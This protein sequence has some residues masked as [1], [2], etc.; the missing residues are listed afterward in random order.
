MLT[1][2]DRIFCWW[3]VADEKLRM[4]VQM[5]AGTHIAEEVDLNKGLCVLFFPHES[6]FIELGDGKHSIKINT[7]ELEVLEEVN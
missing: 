7:M 3:F 1:L 4:C 6:L 2:T 5:T